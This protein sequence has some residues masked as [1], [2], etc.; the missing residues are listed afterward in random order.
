MCGQVLYNSKPNDVIQVTT[1]EKSFHDIVAKAMKMS[2][3]FVFNYLLAEYASS[4]N[5]RTWVDAGLLI[6]KSILD[7]FEIDLTNSV[8]LDRSTQI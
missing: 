5:I 2:D 7:E 4:Q 3:N 8:I 1:L 6:K